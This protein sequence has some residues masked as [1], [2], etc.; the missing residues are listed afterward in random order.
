MVV[1]G[2]RKSA[3]AQ[4]RDDDQNTVHTRAFPNGFVRFPTNLL[5]KILDYK[6]RTKADGDVLTYGE[7]VGSPRP[8]V[9][10]VPCHSCWMSLTCD[11]CL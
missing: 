6:R 10:A 3:G 7:D 1:Y 8:A 9:G 4:A 5:G 2:Y 11:G